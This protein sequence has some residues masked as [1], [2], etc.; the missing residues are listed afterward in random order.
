MF[1]TIVFDTASDEY[2]WSQWIHARLNKGTLIESGGFRRAY[3]CPVK[4][5]QHFADKLFIVKN[6]HEGAIKYRRENLDVL[7]NQGNAS[8]ELNMKVS[9]AFT[10]YV[11]VKIS[12]ALYAVQSQ[13][14]AKI[15]ANKFGEILDQSTH[16]KRNHFM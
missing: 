10:T 7:N 5:A 15:L 1:R 16:G 9:Y 13:A 14:L 11:N 6:F 3:K 12:L 2:K 8:A 4:G